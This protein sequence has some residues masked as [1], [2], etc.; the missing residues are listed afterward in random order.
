MKV[1]VTRPLP[2]AG[3]QLLRDHYDV[4]VYGAQPGSRFD[5]A[6]LIDVA[7]DAAALLTVLSD[8]VTEHVLASCPSLKVVAQFA[9]GYDNI[10][11]AAAHR[12]GIVVTNTPGVLTDATADLAFALLL[13]VARRLREADRYVRDGR[14]QRWETMELLGMEL[15]GKTLGIVGMGRIGQAVARRA[16]G[17]GMRVVYHNRHR[18]NPT[19]E[20]RLGA[21]RVELE[22]LLA[23]S[24][25][26]SLHCPLNDD[27]RHLIDAAAFAQM[28]PSA[29]LINT[30]RG[31][32]VDE[33]ALVE[34]LREGRLAGAGLDVFEREP[35]VH[36]GLLDHPRVVLAPH[37]GSATV[38]ARTAMARMCSEA[39][40]AV[41]SGADDVPYRVA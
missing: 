9:V 28:K 31:P 5:E 10:D 17:F 14:F 34:A 4:H 15:A 24:D 33:A 7:H 16:I 26:I 32:V 40:H 8:P 30:A 27:S 21:R 35:E 39:I 38:E 22:E 19:D 6:G 2:D 18:V 36:P 37:L 20:Y 12:L 1:A 11:V 3:L 23:T 41:L 25:V 29:L 13:A